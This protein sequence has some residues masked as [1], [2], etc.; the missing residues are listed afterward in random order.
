L[1]GDKLRRIIDSELAGGENVLDYGCG[2]RPY[3]SLLLRRFTHYVGADMAG[4]EG[5]DLLL[6]PDGHIPSPDGRFDCVLSSQVLEH[7]GDPLTYLSEAWRVLRPGGSLI[8]S[9]HGIWPYHPDP[10]D[11]WRWTPDGLQRVIRNARF[12]IVSV[13]SVLGPESVALQLWQDATYERLPRALR[14]LYVRFFQACIGVIERRHR[15]KFTSDASAYV[16][17]SRKPALPPAVSGRDTTPGEAPHQPCTPG[18]RAVP[19]G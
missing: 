15:D 5:A 1:L 6:G 7:V 9:T 10:S 16:V 13:Q 19:E 4:N 18:A 3:A 11:F 17:H 2:S 8:L 12:E 14:A